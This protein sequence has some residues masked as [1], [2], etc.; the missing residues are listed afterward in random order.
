MNSRLINNDFN[1]A[2]IEAAK[3]SYQRLIFAVLRRLHQSPTQSNWDDLVQEARIVLAHKLITHKYKSHKAQK[4]LFPY[5]YQSVYWR[6]LDLLRSQQR[7]LVRQASIDNDCPQ[8]PVDHKAQNDFAFCEH[9]LLLNQLRPILTLQQEAYLCLL[10]A[11]YSDTEIAL[12]WHCS[13]QAVSNLRKRIIEKGR[14][15]FQ[16]GC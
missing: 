1:D 3:P 6:I 16:N 5:L 11:G 15:F 2:L 12:R 4:E 13:R 9:D 14:R 10:F 7:R 8:L